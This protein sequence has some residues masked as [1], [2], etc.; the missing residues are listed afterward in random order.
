M[1]IENKLLKRQSSSSYSKVLLFLFSGKVMS[2][3]FVASWTVASQEP[4]SMG[5][6]RKE[7]W[8]RLPFSS[9]GDLSDP[10]FEVKLINMQ[11]EPCFLKTKAF[12]TTSQSSS[13]SPILSWG[14]PRSPASSV[15]HSPYCF[16]HI[17]HSLNK[18]NK[19]SLPILK[20]L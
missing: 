13:S 16:L 19:E 7:F 18:E 10:E 11:T 8:S 3:S 5:F 9:L 1:L 12:V 6:P 20:L 14:G 4:L 17:H 2:D 15:Y